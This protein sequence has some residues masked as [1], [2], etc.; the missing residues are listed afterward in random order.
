M[1]PWP[2]WK[3]W[4]TSPCSSR[5]LQYVLQ[6]LTLS[7]ISP[8]AL[9]TFCALS[10]LIVVTALPRGY[11]H[12]ICEWLYP[13][14]TGEKTETAWG[15][16]LPKVSRLRERGASGFNPGLFAFKTQ[17]RHPTLWRGDVFRGGHVTQAEPVMNQAILLGLLG[18]RSHLHGRSDGAA[19]RS[20]STVTSSEALGQPHLSQPCTWTAKTSRSRVVGL[21]LCLERQ[22]FLIDGAFWQQ[23]SPSLLGLV[24]Y[25]RN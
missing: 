19:E 11:Q 17:P 13:H 21:C 14:F 23:S 12:F 3:A 25:G 8:D 24:F 20:R 16:D 2:C 4:T 15:S 9:G 1:P 5:G 7:S 18:K 10:P 22:Y 6:D